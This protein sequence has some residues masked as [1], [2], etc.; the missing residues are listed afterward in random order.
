ML[1]IFLD[2]SLCSVAVAIHSLDM[3]INAG[4]FPGTTKKL[5]WY[6]VPAVIIVTLHMLI[7]GMH[8]LV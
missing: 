7:S 1:V 3:H 5:H 4:P 2:G 8:E 6:S